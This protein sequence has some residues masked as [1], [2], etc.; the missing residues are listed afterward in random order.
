[1]GLSAA[2]DVSSFDGNA[3]AANEVAGGTAV[4]EESFL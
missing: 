4:E 1:M 3:F 2:V